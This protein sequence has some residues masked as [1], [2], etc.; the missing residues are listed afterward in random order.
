MQY[1]VAS[2][3]KIFNCL[4]ITN[5]DYESRLEPLSGPLF[6]DEEYDATVFLIVKEGSGV[7][8]TIFIPVTFQ[9][10]VTSC[11]YFFDR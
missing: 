7:E 6:N 4:V 3:R 8:I 1:S 5:V 11:N 9:K 10:H 2:S